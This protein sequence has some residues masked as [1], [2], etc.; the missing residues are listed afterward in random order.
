MKV[1]VS[2]PL[3]TSQTPDRCQPPTR[4]PGVTAEPISRDSVLSVAVVVD[5][6]KIATA[7]VLRSRSQ[8]LVQ[9]PSLGRQHCD[10]PASPQT[11]AVPPSDAAAQ[12]IGP[13]PSWQHSSLVPQ[14]SFR[15][16]HCHR[17]AGHSVCSDA[18]VYGSLRWRQCGSGRALP[19]RV[20]RSPSAASR[21]HH[22]SWRVGQSDERSSGR[23]FRGGG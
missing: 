9:E 16:R 21:P 17:G 18:G 2:R 10:V 19:R 20:R 3:P 1:T 22:T 5:A 6:W 4:G 12:E 7:D 11:L 23:P 14:T 13:S 15:S 8:S